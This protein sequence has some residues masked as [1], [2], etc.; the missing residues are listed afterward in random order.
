MKTLN[1][2][3]CINDNKVNNIA[4]FNLLHDILN[5]PK[6]TKTINSMYEYT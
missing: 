1:G 5:P 4:K 6:Q 3:N 2:I